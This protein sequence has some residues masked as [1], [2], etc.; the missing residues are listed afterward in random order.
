MSQVHAGM[1]WDRWSGFTGTGVY[2]ITNKATLTCLDIVIESRGPASDHD[3]IVV[4]G[5]GHCPHVL[6]QLWIIRKDPVSSV[7]IVENLLERELLSGTGMYELV[8]IR[9]KTPQMRSDGWLLDSTMHAL[10]KGKVV[11]FRNIG[12]PGGVLDLP[13]ANN[14]TSA[15]DSL[16]RLR[17]EFEDGIEQDRHKWLLQIQEIGV[18]EA[19]DDD[20]PPASPEIPHSREAMGEVK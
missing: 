13:I 7:C 12:Y 2:V 19:L 4:E 14:E 3:D 1:D 6:S 10:E 9:H 5:S 18:P 11:I 16:V 15:A 8:T 20:S 17:P